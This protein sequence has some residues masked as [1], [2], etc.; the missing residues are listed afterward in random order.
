[1]K[2]WDKKIR[3]KIYIG[4]RGSTSGG[5]LIPFLQDDPLCSK[6]QKNS[7]NQTR[8][9]AVLF[10]DFGSCVSTQSQCSIN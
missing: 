3:D 8:S 1:M 4:N 10:R 5:G 6:N 2:K 7:S 9:E